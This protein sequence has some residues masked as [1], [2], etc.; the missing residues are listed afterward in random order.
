MQGIDGEKAHAYAVLSWARQLSETTSI[1][2]EIAA[3]FHDIDRIVTPGVGG[4]FKGNRNSIDY[5]NHKKAHAM[6]S[7]KFIY[8]EMKKLNI[9]PK[10]IERVAFLIQHHDDPH[11]EVERIND[12]ELDILIS[13][14]SFAF[15]TTIAPK[16]YE[17]EGEVRL[18]DKIKFMVEKMPKFT[19]Q[20]LRSHYVGNDIF[21]RIKNQ[22]FLEL[23]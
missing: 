2:L 10:L 11:Q 7:A 22:V 4:G 1:E 14:D 13:A 17:A 16:L 3:L 15:F 8:N 6:R 21:E 19:K 12:R 5:I 18:H 9:G 20:L 23:E